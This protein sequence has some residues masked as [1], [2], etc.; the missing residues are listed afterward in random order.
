MFPI[1]IPLHANYSESIREQVAGPSGPDSIRFNH[2]RKLQKYKFILHLDWNGARAKYS[3]RVQCSIELLI[4]RRP[5]G[6]RPTRNRPGAPDPR[7][8]GTC[9]E[10]KKY[11]LRLR[12]PSG[13]V[14]LRAIVVLFSFSLPGVSEGGNERNCARCEM[15]TRT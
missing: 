1:L 11:Y 10:M 4:S 2:K 7:P 13:L 12:G 6:T 3:S 14:S 5:A 9:G 8:M 15:E